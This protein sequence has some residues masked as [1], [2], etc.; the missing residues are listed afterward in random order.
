M[1]DLLLRW[2]A[3][4]SLW[5][6]YRV[7][8]VGM[9]QIAAGGTKGI[10]FLP[11]HP[12]LIDPII[13]GT[14]LHKTFRARFLA[15][16]DQIDRFFI[17]R[18][19]GRVN[20][21]PIP[22]PAKVG[23]AARQAVEAG[24]EKCVEALRNGDNVALYPAGQIL[25]G[26]LTNL[27]G[28]SAVEFILG[29]LP[30][31]RVVLVRTTG[32]WGSLFS[33]APGR[34]PNVAEVL[35]KAAVSLLAGGVVFMPR[36]EVTIE[37]HQ[38]DDLPRSAGREE[39][40]RCIE[41]FYNAGEPPATYVP[42]SLWERGGVR[43]MPEPDFRA[44]RGDLSAVP[45]STRQIVAEYLRE[46]TGV[47]EIRD[48][49]HLA[50]DLG[51]DSLGRADLLTWLAGEFGFPPGDVEALETVGDVMLAACGE[52]FSAR[53]KE[54]KPIAAK[55]FSR[56]RRTGL[57]RLPEGRTIPEVFLAQARRGPGAAIVA[58]QASG[59]R[60]YRDVIAAVFVLRPRV[61]EL[62]GERVGIM[63]PAG[64]AAD[65]VYL[66]TL[67][68]GKT[69]V[70]INWTVGPRNLA[71]CVGLVDVRH[72]LTAG[73]LTARLESMGTDLSAVADRLVP[74]ERLAGEVSQAAKLWAWARARTTWSLLDR[75]AAGV[76]ESDAA[77]ILFTSGSEALPKAVPLSHR[78][79]LANLRDIA[80]LRVVRGGDRLLGILPP[81][82]SFGLT[83][84]TVLPLCTAVP[85]VHHPD[86][87]EAPVLA[88][89]IEAYGATIMVG[90]PTFLGAIARAARPEQLASL[91]LAVTGAEKC[92]DRVYE[93]LG[94]VSPK[95]EILEGYGV[96]EC[97]PIVS[98][99]RPGQVR[100]GT[101]GLPMAS[102]RHAVVNVETLEP[103]ARGRTGM[104]LVSGPSV[105]AGYLNYH[106]ATPFVD[107]QG[108]PWYRTGD[109]V[110]EDADG[111]ITFRGRLKRF[112]KMGGEMISLPA[113]EDV[114]Q[115]HFP[116][117][118]GR[119]GPNLAVE[120]AGEEGRSELV[121]FTTRRLDREAV[122]RRIR[123]AGLSGLHNIRRVIH[124]EEI[125]VLGT[126]KTDYRTLRERLN[127]C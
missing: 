63:L 80:A 65:V 34:V 101:I 93:L 99:N 70:M 27:R 107:F 11:N 91:R 61:A 30:D 76:K 64:V 97:S 45:A 92:P 12:A 110:S 102:V 74:L 51:M 103:A 28:N 69:P 83:V 94:R 48:A 81:F 6:R 46:E 57:V 31:V 39:L 86:P 17:R 36:R 7:R 104:L 71:H 60:T 96:T 43:Q 127:P 41:A 35:R 121:L 100:Q 53:L 9:E 4:F 19:A 115:E 21:I 1:M 2:L 47:G 88:R 42:Y 111:V 66:A 117:P 67:L 26:R 15:D 25:R 84:T 108:E 105:F 55:W 78:N 95:M 33:Y 126:G 54:L 112:V 58:D 113:V 14:V 56:P 49:A 20:V 59:L 82:H 116:A 119:E 87:T 75:A 44:A 125:P 68:A 8:T 16:E 52:S 124:V 122:N 18:L 50:R 32:L 89:L 72:I 40:N 85:V 29:R 123:E 37:F 120:A 23:A 38:P 22:D 5:L 79:I 90:T 106:G 118:E 24:L 13:L 3:K 98:V 109:L 62:A 10:L 77:V 73:A 114:L